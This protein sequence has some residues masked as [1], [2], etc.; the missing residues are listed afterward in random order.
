MILIRKINPEDI[1]QFF[2]WRDA[3]IYIYNV[4]RREVMEHKEGKRVIFIALI[5]STIVGTVQ[6]VPHHDDI[7]L[8]DGTSTAYLQSL[9]VDR[10]YRR[11]GIGFNLIQAVEF[12]AISRHFD[13]LTIMVE[14]DNSAALKLYQKMGFSFFKNSHNM[15]RGTQ[16]CVSCLEKSLV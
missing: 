5:N 14:S 12:E 4:L 13:R 8:A 1:Q 16:Y 3:D 7:E 9:L 15:W 6:F 10:N 2:L 11:Q